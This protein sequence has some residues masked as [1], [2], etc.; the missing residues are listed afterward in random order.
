MI[1]IDLSSYRFCRLAVDAAKLC[2]ID[3]SN[4]NPTPKV[5]VVIAV[6]DQLLGWYAKGVKGEVFR[7]EEKTIF[8]APKRMHAEQALLEKLKDQ[9]LSEATAYVTL[10]PCTK[11]RQ[12][13]CCADLM[14]KSGIKTIYI[15]NL[16]PNP[17]V[18]GLAWKT[19]L[20]NEIVIADFP[21]ELRNEALRDN[22][23]FFRK[24]R[25]SPK[26]QDGAAFDYENNTGKRVLGIPPR[27]F[28][29]SWTES[30]DGSIWA[31]DYENYVAI[32]KNCTSFDQIDDPSRWFE[33]A[34][35]TKVVYEGQIVIFRNPYGYVLILIQSVKK[36]T[37][38][39]NSELRFRYE[40]RYSSD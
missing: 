30:G 24:F 4:G 29:T 12:G 27:E 14:V 22:F 26:L 3:T 37:N 10:E 21:P 15:G 5:G 35:Y 18:G 23:D 39:S 17:T 31:L 36:R 13:I 34:D 19:F 25:Y 1:E 6:N 32:A 7:G 2:V 20:E 38:I 16:D 11:K 9:D 33:D 28:H 40:I 8:F